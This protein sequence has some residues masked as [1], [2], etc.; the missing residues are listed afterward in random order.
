[1]L[2]TQSIPDCLIRVWRALAV[3]IRNSPEAILGAMTEDD[4]LMIEIQGGNHRSFEQ[5]VD[6]HESSLLGFFF[7]N[8]RD[9]Q[10]SED[11]TQETLLRV[12]NQAWDYLPR[13]RFRAWLFRVARNLLID[14][15]RRRSHD[16]LV[17]SI[18]AR[19]DQE[20]DLLAALPGDWLCPDEQAGQQELATTVDELLSQLPEEQRLTFTLHHF[21]GLTLSEVADVMETSLPTSKS[22][23]RLAREKL[24]DKL[25]TRGFGEFFQES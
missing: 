15:V 7:R 20:R 23:L 19:P 3:F 5:L 10:L 6:R 22:R 1:M 16:L 24:Q 8:T 21:S 2:W 14:S 25:R 17:R 4:Q 18:K 12:F 13:G 11:L 9:I